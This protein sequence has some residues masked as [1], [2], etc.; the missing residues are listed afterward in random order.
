[1]ALKTKTPAGRDVYVPIEGFI[2]NI[3]GT[4]VNFT[5][6][7]YVREGHPILDKFPHMFRPVRVQYDVEAATADPGEMRDR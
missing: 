3:D 2:A 5:Q 4:D 1:M 7:T 6:H